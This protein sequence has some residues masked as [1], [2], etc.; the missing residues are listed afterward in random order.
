MTGVSGRRRHGGGGAQAASAGLAAIL[1]YAF[2]PLPL[3]VAVAADLGLSAGEAS[4]WIAVVWATGAVAS[5]GL[6]IAHRQPVAITWSVLSLV[7]LGSL[8]GQFTFAELVGANLVAGIAILALALLG[9]GERVMRLVP[10]PIVLG[11]FAGSI[12]EY[13][14]G[15]GAATAADG[16]VAGSAVAGYLAARAL[17]SRRLP[18]VAVAVLCGAAAVAATGGIGPVDGAW[19]PP[20]LG[21]PGIE[22]SPAAVLTVSPPLVV[23]ALAL[24]NVQGLGYMVAQGYRPPVTAISLAVGAA[25]IL[26]ALLGGHQASVG[27]ATSPIV[28]GPDA[29][30]AE[31]RWRASV[32]ASVGALGIAAAAGPVVGLVG[33]LPA[34]FVAVVCGLALLGPFQESLQRSLDGPLRL[35]ALVA[36]IVAATP[37]TAAGIGSSSWALAAG[38]A[39]SLAVEREALRGILRAR[40]RPQVATAS[41]PRSGAIPRFAAVASALTRRRTASASSP[42]AP[43]EAS[44]PARSAAAHA[45]SGR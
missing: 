1:F 23:F 37:F 30:P 41:R 9:V 45:S 8:A 26:N 17:G 29:G 28:G 15:A 21:V 34:S 43:R 2:V 40:P 14:T 25:S 31:G 36:F 6:S 42:S 44:A 16:A 38:V 18:P 39:T 7:Y 10:M 5:I 19:S 27:R 22:L 12:L 33:A 13:V 20:A 11:M 4:R 3:A 35:G 24:G 32:V